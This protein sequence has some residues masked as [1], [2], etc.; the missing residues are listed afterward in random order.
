MKTS[1]KIFF[2]QII[3]KHNSMIKAIV[4]KKIGKMTPDWEDVVANIYLS[5]WIALKHFEG[6]SSINTYIYPI[7]NYRIADYLR[8]L[9]REKKIMSTLQNKLS[10][11]KKDLSA[12]LGGSLEDRKEKIKKEKALNFLSPAEFRIFKLIG[13][14]MTNDEIANTLFI[15]KNT[16][17][18]HYKKVSSKLDFNDRVKLALF[19]YRF[20]NGGMS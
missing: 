20:I 7:V 18:T 19:S 12:R 11:K 9:Y 4:I 8:H 10:E 16:V 15:S 13:Q 14:G 1:S 5:I 3:D 2:E 17:R 6:R